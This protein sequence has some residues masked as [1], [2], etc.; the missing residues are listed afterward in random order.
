VTADRA[1]GPV[2]LT[3]AIPFHRGIGFLREAI[4][5]AR[6]QT[7][8]D[9]RLVVFDDRGEPAREVEAAVAGFEDPRLAW[10]P[11]PATLGMA[12]NWNHAL[13]TVETDLVTLVHA[14]DRL[15]PEYAATVLALA[16]R[17]PEAAAVCCAARLIDAAGRPTWTVAD[18]YKRLLVP[19]GEP[20]R[21]RGE[22]GLHALLR[23]DFVM[24]PT[25]CWRRSVLRERRFDPG[26]R[27]VQDL[28]LLTRLLLEGDEIAGT[29]HPAYAYR[30]HGESATAVQSASL[31]RF[32]EEFAL[33]D[34]LAE[35]AA[36]LGWPRAAR[37][38]RRK[39]VVRL[40]LGLHAAADL[41]RGRPA[42]ALRKLARAA[43]GRGAAA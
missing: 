29:H 30:R 15:L 42:G 37:A 16:G 14:D 23:G 1:P 4:A 26:W 34:R 18:A 39:L 22:R 7:V 12:A 11:N 40:H 35:R 38:A 20:W 2:R 41:A 27:Q 25:L 32:D 3:F 13:D 28:E 36:G 10:R 5:S 19:R 33:Y 8:P 24:C 21:L 31:L 43:R 9:W 17:H 6:A